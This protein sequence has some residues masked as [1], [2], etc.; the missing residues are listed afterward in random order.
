M[1]II[2]EDLAKRNLENYSFSDYKAG[3]ATAE[4]NA[5]IKDAKERIE[6]AKERVS[7]EGKARLDN[8]LA[9]FSSNY[10]SW[11]NKHN[12]SGAGHVSSMISGPANYNMSKHNKWLARE[13]KLWEEYNEITDIASQISRI[14][15]GDK[16]IKSDDENAIEKLTDK[17]NKALEEH[18]GYKAYNAKARK[19]GKEILAAYVLQNSNG[20]IK[21]IKDRIARL[22]RLAKQE[23]EVIEIQPETEETSGIKIIDNVQAQRLQ[24]IFPGKPD[25]EVRNELKKNGF[26]WCPTNTAWQCYRSPYAM[27]KAKKIVENYR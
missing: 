26:R 25:A 15:T 23:T 11:T 2:N 24:I 5:V 6:K 13:G 27:D 8:L 1:S 14:V 7:E 17:L 16:I 9:R 18:E 19:E 10:A 22:E 3:S 21:G 20:R 4:Y 12:A